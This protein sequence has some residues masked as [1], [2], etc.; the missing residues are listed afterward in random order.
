MVLWCVTQA[1]AQRGSSSAP[2]KRRSARVAKVLN[3]NLDSNAGMSFVEREKKAQITQTLKLKKAARLQL[4]DKLTTAQALRAAG[5]PADVSGRSNWGDKLRRIRGHLEKHLEDWV[6]DHWGGRSSPPISAASSPANSRPT[7]PTPGASATP[8]LFLP[9]GKEQEPSDYAATLESKIAALEASKRASKALKLRVTRRDSKVKAT[10][11]KLAVERKAHAHTREEAAHFNNEAE[12]AKQALEEWISANAEDPEVQLCTSLCKELQTWE[13]GRY[14]TPIRFIY[15]QLI[16]DNVSPNVVQHT[17]RTILTLAGVKAGRLPGR[18]T[19]QLMKAEMAVLADQDA[20][21][22]LSEQPD[23]SVA[24]AGD[25]ATKLGKSRFALG[26]FFAD[27]IGDPIIFAALGVLD[28]MG[29]TADKT[30]DAI[31]DLL[32]RIAQNHTLMKK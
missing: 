12:L 17:V 27:S 14:S 32:T 25:E 1:A 4:T 3:S 26:M 29:G 20:G 5:L 28:A 23:G 19:A 16:R 24:L 6:G 7:S 22:T 10:E 30:V 8:Q 2:S 9:I 11:E 21:A 31:I 18:T 13:G 15:M